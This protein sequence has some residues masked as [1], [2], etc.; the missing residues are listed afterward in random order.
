MTP[1]NVEAV[2][3]LEK[4]CFSSPWSLDSMVK[5]LSNPIA[6]YYTAFENGLLAGYIGMHYIIDEGYI[7]NVAV[8]E[9]H[10]RRGVATLLLKTLL[11]CGREKNLCALTL[12]ARASNQAAIAL[13]KRFGF[14]QAG[15]RKAYY[16]LPTED[17]LLMTLVLHHD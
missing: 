7:N 14:R 16:T 2:A 10:R 15:L 5:E 6:V 4:E 13:Y 9:S 1:E 17:A 11:D 8:R 12:E 3:A